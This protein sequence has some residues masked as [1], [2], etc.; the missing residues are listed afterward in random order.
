MVAQVVLLAWLLGLSL[1]MA[2]PLGATL[3][4]PN[5]FR[6]GGQVVDYQPP[7]T[8]EQA[9]EIAELLEIVRPDAQ[10]TPVRIRRSRDGYSLWIAFPAE[11]WLD[12][13]NKQQAEWAGGLV[14]AAVLDGAP[15]TVH[16]S[17]GNL[18]SR[19]ALSL[20]LEPEG[21]HFYRG[22]AL[23]LRKRSI[24]A[25]EEFRKPSSSDRK[26]LPFSCVTVRPCSGSGETPRPSRRP[27]SRSRSIPTMR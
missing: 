11:T 17:D 27:G 14:S 3:P 8:A 7:V 19:R 5:E 20:A 24:E 1:G 13:A 18:E 26:I 22:E 6:L 12:P 21:V 25:I 4:P 23:A 15:L 16:M 10:E 9:R 2:V